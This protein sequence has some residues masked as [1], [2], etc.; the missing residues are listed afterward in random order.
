MF[1]SHSLHIFWFYWSVSESTSMIMRSTE[2]NTNSSG[3]L[4]NKLPCGFSVAFRDPGFKVDARIKL[5]IHRMDMAA[6]TVKRQ[7]LWYTV[8]FKISS[9]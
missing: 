7:K 2:I 3:T 1:S 8:Y 9:Q 6:Y 5:V 4:T